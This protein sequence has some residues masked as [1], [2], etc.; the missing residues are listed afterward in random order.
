M[1]LCLSCHGVCT[2]QYWVEVTDTFHH[3]IQLLQSHYFPFSPAAELLASLAH[4]RAGIPDAIVTLGAVTHLSAHLNSP[5][6][7]V[8]SPQCYRQPIGARRFYLSTPALLNIVLRN[9]KNN[10]LFHRYALLVQLHLD[11][12][13]STVTLTA[14]F[15]WNAGTLR[16]HTTY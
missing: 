10:S 13:P 14:C 7:E 8:S 5:E 1:A 6:E 16:P 15:W 11:T 12:S 3:C 9:M 4:T 2:S